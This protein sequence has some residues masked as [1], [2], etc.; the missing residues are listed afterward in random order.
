MQGIGGHGFLRDR[1]TTQPAAAGQPVTPVWQCA[2]ELRDSPVRFRARVAEKPLRS[3]CELDQEV[4]AR[5]SN[6]RDTHIA[7][8]PRQM[9]CTFGSVTAGP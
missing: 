3:P 6:A 5:Q 1:P 7:P 2:Y 4:V 8:V 9:P